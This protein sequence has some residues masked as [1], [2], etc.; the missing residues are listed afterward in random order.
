M[1]DSSISASSKDSATRMPRDTPS[2]PVNN[3]HTHMPYS[4][5]AIHSTAHLPVSQ[6]L[7]QCP[8]LSTPPALLHPLCSCAVPSLT[9]S[10]TLL[11]AHASLFRQWLL[12][13]TSLLKLLSSL[14]SA[15][16]HTNTDV[17]RIAPSALEAFLL[18]LVDALV[19]GEAA[20]G[21][22]KEEGQGKV[23]ENGATSTAKVV[24][25]D[26]S[27]PS[28]ASP[29]SSADRRRLFQLLL[30]TFRMKLDD[31]RSVMEASLSI[32]AFGYLAKA[33]A[34]FSGQGELTALIA[35]LFKSSDALFQATSLDE[36]DQLHSQFSAFLTSFSLILRHLHRLEPSLVDHLHRVISRFLHLY[37][38]LS[39]AQKDRN[40]IAFTKL[41]VVLH[42]CHPQHFQVIL[43]S[44]VHELLLLTISRPPEPRVGF[45][46]N[47]LERQAYV[48]YSYLWL[49]CT[50]VWVPPDGRRM[51]M[52]RPS[53]AWNVALNFDV[54]AVKPVRRAILDQMMQEIIRILQQL[55]LTLQP[56]QPQQATVD[57]VIL[58]PSSTST[59][60]PLFLLF[61]FIRYVFG[62]FV[63]WGVVV[64]GAA[65]C[66]EGLSAV[67]Q[68]G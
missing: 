14:L 68:P 15:C 46:S 28:G 6:S 16:R 39:D 58:P 53:L 64:S 63:R 10:L 1:W 43:D 27:A 40:V 20:K 31:Q 65:E 22:E 12:D 32:R 2:S 56:A 17:A 60:S 5:H 36:R 51:G 57:G 55:D 34:V 47:G 50:G 62:L 52:E 25:A 35:L 26:T 18:A 11:K 42:Q 67:P 37:P 45:D 19:E 3:T 54:N 48:E 41:L 61:F 29:I 33:V 21:E 8:L 38:N 59:T 30:T 23:G 9:A 7:M 66:G 44:A 49:H 13:E 4:L 24:P